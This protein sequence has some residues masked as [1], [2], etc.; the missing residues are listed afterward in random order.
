MQR[1]RGRR[2]RQRA[3]LRLDHIIQA[4]VLSDRR[5]IERNRI[6]VFVYVLSAAGSADPLKGQRLFAGPRHIFHAAVLLLFRNC[7]G[8]TGNVLI[9]SIIRIR[10]AVR[11]QLDVL[12]IVELQHILACVCGD[13]DLFGVCLSEGI[14]R[15]GHNHPACAVLR[16]LDR[17]AI[18]RG[19]AL[20]SIRMERLSIRII[21][22]ANPVVLD[23]VGIVVQL[24]F[25]RKNRILIQTLFILGQIL[26]GHFRCEFRLIGNPFGLPFGRPSGYLVPANKLVPR[27]CRGL[28]AGDR[29]AVCLLSGRLQNDLLCRRSNRAVVALPTEN[30]VGDRGVLSFIRH[31]LRRERRIH[32][33]AVL[34]LVQ[35]FLGHFRRQGQV[36]CY[37]FVAHPSNLYPLFGV[38]STSVR[39]SPVTICAS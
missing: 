30:R 29:I 6:S 13:R 8:I 20:V 18:R 27:L 25:R 14:H 7:A 15:V 32:I 37:T 12:I 33:Q 3:R 9:F 11:D 38:A 2:D 39:P 10:F 5:I 23:R 16:I 31:K 4:V 19:L 21:L 35:F 17:A 26:L 22:V 34:V 28:R 24:K 1:N 36:S